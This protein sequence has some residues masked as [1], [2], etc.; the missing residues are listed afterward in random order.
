MHFYY[1]IEKKGNVEYF[2]VQTSN[3]EVAFAKAFEHY[4]RAN[5]EMLYGPHKSRKA[6][7]NEIAEME[8][9][10]FI[11]DYSREIMRGS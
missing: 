7:L 9:E 5:G 6:L 8:D 4:S 11:Y 10:Q 1:A 3:A 2:T